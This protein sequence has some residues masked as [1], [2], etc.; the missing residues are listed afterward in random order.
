MK[1][2]KPRKK[3]LKK[4]KL[5]GRMIPRA[6]EHS[7]KVLY[8]LKAKTGN[9]IRHELESGRLNLAFVVDDSDSAYV[10]VR[11]LPFCRKA[12]RIGRGSITHIWSK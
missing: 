7:M 11:C 10:T 5:K 8:G 6:S 12:Y 9:L 1:R 2:V 3:S 4:V